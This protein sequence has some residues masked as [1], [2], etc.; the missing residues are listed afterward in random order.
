MAWLLPAF[1]FCS[2]NQ[3]GSLNFIGTYYEEGYT[4]N[5]QNEKWMFLSASFMAKFELFLVLTQENTFS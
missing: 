2:H 1:P 4:S 3:I 5:R